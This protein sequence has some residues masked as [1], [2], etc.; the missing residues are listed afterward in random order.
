M[1]QLVARAP[2]SMSI[3]NSL[4][5]RV[6]VWQGFSGRNR[7]N[8]HSSHRIRRKRL[9]AHFKRPYRNCPDHTD[10]SSPHFRFGAVPI[11]IYRFSLS[12]CAGYPSCS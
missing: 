2:T 12:I 4:L 1:M 6:H 7:L 3:Y 5:S 10:L 11:G 9:A 8:S